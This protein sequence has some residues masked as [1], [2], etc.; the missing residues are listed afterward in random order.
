[1]SATIKDVA[2]LAGVSPS[3][4]TRTCQN[5]PSISEET[6]R[7]VRSAMSALGYTSNYPGSAADFFCCQINCHCISAF[8][9]Q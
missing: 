8:K 5:Q 2:K 3:T 1:M 4:V 9:T 7:K 6:K